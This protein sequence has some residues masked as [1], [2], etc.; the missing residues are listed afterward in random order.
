[1]LTLHNHGLVDLIHEYAALT[2]WWYCDSETRQWLHPPPGR[3]NLA[4]N[5]KTS[6]C[7]LHHILTSARQFQVLL[8]QETK[9]RLVT[10]DHFLV[11]ET[12]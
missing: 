8:T 9:I 2:Y 3:F 12:C 1:M 5:M 6:G 4:V 11:Y 10:E 7:Q